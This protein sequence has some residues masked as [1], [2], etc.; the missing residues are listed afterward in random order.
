MKQTT[1]ESWRDKYRQGCIN[2]EFGFGFSFSRAIIKLKSLE[3]F[4]VLPELILGNKI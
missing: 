1:T 3:I 4:K 2:L